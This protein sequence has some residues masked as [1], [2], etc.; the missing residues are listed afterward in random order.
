MVSLLSIPFLLAGG[1]LR[2]FDFGRRTIPL[3]VWLAPVFLLGFSRLNE[4]II[5][6]PAVGT[7][8]FLAALVAYR[9]VIPV[10]GL[11][12]PAIVAV[13]AVI[14]TLPFLSDRLLFT[15]LPGFTS[16]L[17]F[18]LTWVLVELL[19]ARFHP[20]GSWGSVAYTQYGN[21]PLMQ[22]ASITGI[23][24]I[25]FLV[26]W[27]G[28]TISWAWG[29]GFDW[30]LIRGGL[31]IYGLVLSLVML[32]G[33]AR[34][35]FTKYQKTARTAAI[36]WPEK[37][38]NSDQMMGLFTSSLVA[39]QTDD[40]GREKM[41]QLQGY[42]LNATRREARA[43]SKIV[44]WPEINLI[45][46]QEDEAAFIDQARQLAQEQSIFILMGMGVLCLGESKPLVNK[47]VLINPRGEVAF[48]YLKSRPVPGPEAM[49]QVRG[50]GNIPTYD[51]EY[52]RLASP[53]C[54][55]MDF[56]SFIRQVGQAETDILLV[57]AS[58]W[59]PI[60]RLHHIMA[61]FR[62][63]E[64]GT[65]ML[66]ATR[67]G[68]SSAVDPLGRSLA[69]MDDLVS[70]QQSMVAHL[71]TQ[72]ARTLYARFGDLFAWICTVSLAGIILWTVIY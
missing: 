65:S 62:A 67:W 2:L 54:F 44:V 46:L 4:P 61:V 56:P 13:Y 41:R 10:P 20:Y 37:I 27:F 25:T 59:A 23:A 34:I 58:D 50:D 68:T 18:P 30:S 71:P 22:L 64:N 70:P 1:G 28:S 42:F 6:I 48:S 53:I 15:Q 40:E 8:I 60:K 11:I 26:T 19:S 33:G 36:G 38:M 29:Q 39:G 16:T 35:A 24:G 51:S 5:A 32:Y 57:P 17:I 21:Q 69:I 47:S 9:G 72:G 3:A 63:V 66:R 12:Y 7:V 43:G 55:D 31:L 45:I 49:Y 52:G 14:W